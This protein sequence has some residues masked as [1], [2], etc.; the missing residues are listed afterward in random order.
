[1]ESVHVAFNWYGQDSNLGTLMTR[2]PYSSRLNA[3]I[4]TQAPW[5]QGNPHSSR[6]NTRIRTQAPWWQ[7]NPYSSRLN[8]RIR[9]Q[10]PW[11]QGN[12]YSSRL[13]VRIRTQA[14]WWQG[15]TY[16]SRLNA[17]SLRCWLKCQRWNHM[18]NYE[19]DKPAFSSLDVINVWLKKTFTVPLHGVSFHGTADRCSKA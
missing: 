2:N 16:S 15:N 10:A 17:H 19:A 8:A 5:W 18:Y 12:P 3:R 14:P 9:T 7:G 11:W 6:L 4:R 1:M 13:N